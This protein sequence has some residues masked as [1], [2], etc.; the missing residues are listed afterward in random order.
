MYGSVKI[1]NRV[2]LHTLG[3]KV[4]HYETEAISEQ[5]VAQG[6]ERVNFD[7]LAD[8]YII[9]TCTVTNNAARKS[10]QMIRRAIK[11]N[12]VAI[13]VVIGCYSQLAEDLVATI[14]GV[15]IIIGTQH[16]NKVAELVVEYQASVAEQDRI[17]PEFT[18]INNVTDIMKL[19]A[20]EELSLAGFSDRTRATVKI[21]D[22]CNNFCTYCII[23][24]ARGLSRSRQPEAIIK[25]VHQLVANDYKEVVLTGIHTGAFGEDLQD[26]CLAELLRELVTIEGLERIRVSS[27]E[28]TQITKEFLGVLQESEKIARH[29]HIPLQA[30]DDRILKAMK[31]NYNTAQFSEKLAEVRAI[32]PEIAITTDV[33]TGFPG[34]TDEDY[35]NG[36]RFIKEM[37]FSELHVF[38]Y[39]KRTGTPAALMSG[40]I[41]NEV[42]H[43]RAM[44]LIELSNKLAFAYRSRFVGDVLSVIPEV[45]Q[46]KQLINFELRGH[47]DNYIPVVF[48]GDSSLIGTICQVR[49]E[50]VS[51]NFCRGRLV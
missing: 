5:L 45:L 29:L 20:Y 13:I 35:L 36:Y 51:A 6:Y 8:V 48:A 23:P 27:I 41:T 12:P 33:I 22:G 32:M 25:Q 10:R 24:W 39:S 26:Y 28:V 49:L 38:P 40:Q 19:R 46:D 2:A 18:G 50:K 21:Q 17:S 7:E 47:S 9:N 4:N 30:G 34:E 3:C 16:K 42:K 44:E 11:L 1:K 37:S 43:E 31:R 15:D 14:P